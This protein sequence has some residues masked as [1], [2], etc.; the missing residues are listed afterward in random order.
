MTLP[1]E[2]FKLITPTHVLL[3]IRGWELYDKTLVDPEVTNA[4][5]TGEYLSPFINAGKLTR[6][7][8]G[9]SDYPSFVFYGEKGASDAQFFGGM[10]VPIIQHGSFMADTWL[11][12]RGAG[13]AT[14]GKPLTAKLVAI[15]AINRSVLTE[16]AGTEK[17]L[18]YIVTLPASATAP[19][20]YLG[21][22]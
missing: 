13:V 18:G 19:L 9:G 11:F 16:S 5:V 15:D 17:V 20:R 10:R 4:L 21:N 1:K 2:P 8:A 14:L 7:G 12:N 3:H 22:W 6:L